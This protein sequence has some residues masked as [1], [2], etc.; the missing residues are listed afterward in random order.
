MSEIL[1]YGANGYTGVLIAE[2]A[3]RR[4]LTPILAGRREGAVRPLA[5]RHGMPWRAFSLDDAGAVRAGLDGV[6]TVLH[7]AG[8]FSATSAPMLDACL[9]A[10]A[11]YLDVT[12]EISVFEA[13]HG[14]DPEAKRAGI[15]VM[16]GV[17]FDVVPSDCLALTLREALPDAHRLV[18]AFGGGAGTSRG[19]TMTMVEG[20]PDGGAIREGGIIRSVPAAWDARTIPFADKPRWG[21]TIPWGDVSTAYYTTGIPNI[22]V[23]LAMPRSSVTAVRLSRP[24]LPLLKLGLVQSALKRAVDAFVT[25]PDA[26]ARARAKTEL[27]GRVESPDGRSVE[28]TLQTPEGYTL[29]AATAIEIAVRVAAGEVEAG[30]RTPAGAFGSSFITTFDRCA[31]QLAGEPVRAPAVVS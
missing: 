22:A 14:R 1:V 2:E 12:G 23:Y 13:C 31:M 15:V 24:V 18:L 30:A 17:G 26:E 10:G 3:A 5:E 27:W 9:A 4:G 8:P 16:P 11:H 29:T 28:A 19:T 25:G 20:F 21:V 7:S 6:S